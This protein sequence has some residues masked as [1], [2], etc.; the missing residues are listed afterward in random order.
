MIAHLGDHHGLPLL[1]GVVTQSLPSWLIT[2]FYGDSGSCTTLSKEIRRMRLE[3]ISWHEILNRIITAL[4]HM[5]A[6]GVIHNNIKSNNVVLEKRGEE[7]NPVIIDFG[8]VRLVTNPKP[9]MELS[10]SAQEEYQRSYPHIAQ[11]IV[12]G[13][14]LQSVVSGVFSFGKITI[15]ILNLLPTATAVSINM[16]KKLTSGDP[17]KRPPLNDFVAALDMQA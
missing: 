1:F 8:K 5:D 7:Q 9:V 14:G 4:N 3:K 12:C 15:R 6:A 16:A 10:V 13:K 17:A 11:E 2:Q